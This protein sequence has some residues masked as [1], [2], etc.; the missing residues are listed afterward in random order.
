MLRIKMVKISIIM[1]IFNDEKLLKKSIGSVINQSLEDIELICVNDG[2]T[3]NSLS[4]LNK[5][6]KKYDFIRVYTQ[7]NQGSGIARNK[8]I[9]IAKGEYIAFLDA[10]DFFIDKD[11]LEKLYDIA[12]S[13]NANLV[14]GNMKLVNSNN[15]FLPFKDLD[16]YEENRIILPE[17]YG[18]PWGFYKNIYKREFLTSNDI[19]FP[20]LIRG[21]DPVFLAEVLSKLD[22]IYTVNTDFY[23]YYYIDGAN[24]CNSSKKI[25]DHIKQFKYVFNYFK[26]PKFN[27]VKA[28]F[29]Y[30]LFVFIGMMGVE[31]AECVLSSIRK[32]FVDNP[33]FIKR[34]E[35]YY[36]LK[37][38]NDKELMKTLNIN[39]K[40]PR[41][42]VV[43]PVY[44][45]E[46]FL[47]EAM[48]SLINQNFKDFE[49]ICV[50]DGSPDDSLSILE[51]YASKDNRI[52]IIN[53][54]NAGCGAARNKALDYCNGEYIYF[55][56]PDDYIASNA[57]YKLYENAIINDSDLVIFKIARFHEKNKIDYKNAGFDFEKVF[58]DVDFKH[59]TFT[60]HDVKPYVLNKA[61]APWTKLYKKE[62]LDSY[63]DFR[64]DLGVAFDDVPFHVKSM[65]RAKKISYIPD[66]FYFYRFNPN[67][68][69]NTSSNRMD[70]YKII[71]IVED[72]LKDNNYL[73]E[74]KYEFDFFKV[75]QILIYI[76]S[77][78]SEEYFNKA[79][80]EF[81]NM[82]LS[83]N[84]LIYP[85]YIDLVNIVLDS[86]SFSEFKLSYYKFEIKSLSVEKEILEKRLVNLKEKNDYLNNEK[87]LI[88]KSKSWKITKPLRKVKHIF[89]K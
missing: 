71:N 87:N 81:S 88:L 14:S 29:E 77:T 68:I 85:R 42:S 28:D 22:C 65:L 54:K 67:S 2:S 51:D 21:Q 86:N 59:F 52:K 48:N 13:N 30:K 73:D 41:I 56:D 69:N 7:K 75:S 5:Y 16:Y 50:N 80:D 32:I 53:Q 4:I 79:K 78:N 18:I 31:N 39:T 20:D 34:F 64:F 82:D 58:K 36:Y 27:R 25:Q 15:E 1:P 38:S 40:K 3:D 72:F 63:D 66:F 74:F 10:D 49:V 11:S 19:Y 60:C 24:K 12:S 8:G 55:F 83:D 35:D 76:M 70:I 62:L 26:N 37:Y 9:K 46:P 45:A 44:N 43:V 17:N 89:K 6:S 47:N 57:F 84:D 33:N 61:F 23:A